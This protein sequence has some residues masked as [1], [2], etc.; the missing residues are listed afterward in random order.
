L[1]QEADF[2]VEKEGAKIAKKYMSEIQAF[3]CFAPSWCS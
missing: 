2:F 1:K 3:V